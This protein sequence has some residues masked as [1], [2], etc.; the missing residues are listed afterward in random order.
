M[1]QLLG[2]R[3]VNRD[4]R[5]I[6]RALTV[7]EADALVNAAR[8]PRRRLLYVLRFCT[9]LRV[10]EASRLEWSDLDLDDGLLRLRASITKNAK[11]D[12]IPIAADLDDEIARYQRQ[13]LR[14]GQTLTD[15]I[16]PSVPSRPTWRRDLD[17][18]GVQWMV[19]GEQADRK[20]TRK[21]F[22]S[23]L[24]RSGCDIA[25]VMLLMRHTPRGGM[26]LTLGPYADVQELLD[27]KRA[28]ITAMTTWQEQERKAAKCNTG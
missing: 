11:A 6:S 13:A 27:R 4:H 14:N 9:G 2:E 22:E 18:A 5:R 8:D 28:A 17:R 25:I 26:A 15:R 1:D 3:P 20:C 24:L 12:L 19:G 7:A 23:H 10:L 16:F 21:T